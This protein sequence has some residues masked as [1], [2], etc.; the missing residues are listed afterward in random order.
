MKSI[1]E[2]IREERLKLLEKK[3]LPNWMTTNG[4]LLLKEKYLSDGETPKDRYKT[5][6]KTLAK[7]TKNP[8]E[9]EKKFFNEFW[10]G[11]TAASTP[12]LS[13]TGTNNGQSVSCSSA[14]IGD[15]IHD[16]YNTQTE[17]ALL[18]KNGFGTSGFLGDIRSRGE[19]ISV[20]GKAS[21]ILPVFKDYVQLSRD[22]SQGS[23]RRGAWAGYVPIDHG[24]FWELVTFVLNN[25]D[26]ANIG[27][28]IYD[29][30]IDKLI[31]GDL[32]A[33]SRY[34]EALKVKCVTGKGYFW[35]PDKVNRLKP[36]WYKKY[37]LVNKSSNL[38]VAPETQILTKNG[39]IPIFELENQLID[40][41][42]GEEWSNVKIR[43]TGTNQ[44]L[45][46]V[47]T[48]A[49]NTL[50]CT[51]YHKFYIFD[52]YGKPYKEVRASELAPGD[53]LCKFDLPIIEGEKSLNK[54]YING[55]YSGD[56][57]LT[58]EGQRVY[59]YHDKIKLKEEFQGGSDWKV[60]PEHKRA[61][62]HYNDLKDKFFVPTSEYSIE[63]KLECL[64][65]W[66]DSD[67]CIYKNGTN[68]QITGASVELNFLREVQLMLQT[69]GVSSKISKFREEGFK[70][71][72]TNDGTG[73]LKPFWCKN[74]FRL[75]ITSNDSYKLLTLGL[76]LRRLKIKERLPTRDAKRFNVVTEILD[77][78]RIDD[79]YCFSEPKR[80]MGMFNGMLTGQCTEIDLHSDLEHTFTCILSSKNI[81]KY[82]E[83]KN[84]DSV[85]VSTVMLDCVCSDFIEKAKDIVGIEKAIRFT[86]KARALGL[87][88]LGF[89]T[90]LQKNKIA[91]ESFEAHLTNTE[92]FSR[93]KSEAVKASEWMAKEFGE[94]EW[95]KGFN[96]RNTD[97]LAIAPNTSSALICGG[98]SQGIEPVYQNVYTQ[99]SSAGEMN[100]INPV[101]LE[102]MKEKNVY[103][104]STLNSIIEKKGSVQHVDWLT[105]D[106]KLV[107]KTAFEIDQRAILRLA[108]TRQKFIC[109]GQSLNLFFAADEDE[110]YI[111]EIHKEAFLDPNIKGLYYLRSLAGV[112]VSKDECLS[113]EG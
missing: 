20:G 17:T 87:G 2:E 5:I 70:N 80:H 101:L 35:F 61:Y 28:V 24:D 110:A 98:V 69:L 46:K 86:R 1:Y 71:L 21:G 33:I 22:V 104:S 54:A 38:C 40:V 29:S 6:A 3:A 103:S 77:E 50:E 68:E 53:K 9:W 72:P 31:A 95:A 23:Q 83:W 74:C 11:W 62:K 76:N 34:Q 57:C 51:P 8:K 36:E 81:A 97:L 27:W 49:G 85:F 65:G 55:F 100:R 78:G 109:Q 66:L 67:G 25:P 82:D 92:I 96:R 60:Q 43:K 45:I 13:N 37:N 91:F 108:S 102:V 88:A 42:N 59:L 90:Y 73:N 63:S 94:P 32:D 107:F 7:Y 14:Y 79:T 47:K 106:Q 64:A 75:L 113:C 48:S 30:F 19:P 111:S 15:S 16:F 99:G 58:K 52:G 4:Y 39:Y 56:G 93:I 89:H 84:T 105:E 18:S 44:R 12:V 26:D 10:K 112:E 41:W